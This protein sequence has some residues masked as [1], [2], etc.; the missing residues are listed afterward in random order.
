MRRGRGKQPT[1]GTQDRDNPDR[2]TPNRQQT[3]TER[4]PV[5]RQKTTHRAKTIPNT[6]RSDPGASP[7]GRPS[8]KFLWRCGGFAFANINL[9]TNYIQ[10]FQFSRPSLSFPVLPN[11]LNVSR[12]MTTSTLPAVRILPP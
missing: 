12:K 7:N 1:S 2:H 3:L 5:F 8:D 10:A 6:V 11:N 4:Q 9:Y